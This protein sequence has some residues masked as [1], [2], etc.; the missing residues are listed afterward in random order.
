MSKPRDSGSETMAADGKQLDH[1]EFVT[2][3]IDDQWFGIPVQNVQDV[4]GTQ[5]I[6]RIP[7]AP[8]EVAGSLNLRGRIVTAIDP[9][10]RLGLPERAA[11]AS[12]MSIVVEHCDD[13]YS[14]LIDQVGEVLNLPADRFERNPASL[15]GRWRD[16]SAGVYRLDDRLMIVM[17][18]ERLLDFDKSMVA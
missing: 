4:L 1:N 18:V 14:L 13:L 12:V 3:T 8:P 9:R 15:D 2:M 5:N 11:D 17:D 7:L 10:V 16:I 6:A